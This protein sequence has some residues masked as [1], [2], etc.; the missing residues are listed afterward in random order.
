MDPLGTLKNSKMEILLFLF[1]CKLL[2]FV[3]Q[4]YECIFSYNI[5]FFS[6]KIVKNVEDAMTKSCLSNKLSITINA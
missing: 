5:V 2:K 3:Y 1:Y 6:K 4:N